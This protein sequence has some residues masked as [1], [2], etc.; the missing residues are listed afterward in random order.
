M[1]RVLFVCLGNICRSPMAE[2]VF[3]HKVRAAGLETSIE[4]DSAGTG[5]WHVGRVGA[6]RHA[7]VAKAK[8][9]RIQRAG[10]TDCARRPGSLRLY[11]DDG[12]RQFA[13]RAGIGVA[14]RCPR[15]YRALA[16]LC[17]ASGEWRRFLIPGT[18]VAFTPCTISW[19]WRPR[20]C[21]PKF[22]GSMACE[23]FRSSDRSRQRRESGCENRNRAGA[24]FRQMKRRPAECFQR[25]KR[26]E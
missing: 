12:Q 10:A 1:V 4:A 25:R 21:S 18:M 13:R 24:G 5:N 23:R 17:A 16:L 22:A 2:A 8:R 20:T 6:P 26:T 7:G 9:D 15:S 11:R 14:G 19:T 3:A